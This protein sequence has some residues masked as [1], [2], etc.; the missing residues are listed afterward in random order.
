MACP[1]VP[2]RVMLPC[3]AEYNQ[4]AMWPS[5]HLVCSK[6][7][8]NI[9]FMPINFQGISC[10]G[11]LDVSSIVSPILTGQW[12]EL[13]LYPGY[14]Y[15]AYKG[16]KNQVV[17]KFLQLIVFNNFFLLQMTSLTVYDARPESLVYY[18]HEFHL[19][20]LKVK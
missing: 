14:T 4:F 15:A 1:P 16:A 9:F 3:Y 20:D 11:L 6:D 13:D 2:I 7:I 18:S 17:E 5:P 8:I 10:Y 12:L 19:M